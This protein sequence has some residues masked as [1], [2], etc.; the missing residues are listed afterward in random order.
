MTQSMNPVILH[1]YQFH[2]DV[3]SYYYFIHISFSIYNRINTNNNRNW[4]GCDHHWKR[5]LCAFN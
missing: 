2:M 4:A 1:Y 5:N 3:F